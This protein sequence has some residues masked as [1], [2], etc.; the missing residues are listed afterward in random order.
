MSAESQPVF[1]PRGAESWRD[2]FGMYKALRDHDP[3]HHVPD[4]GEGE[5]YWVLSRFGHVIDAAVDAGTFSS[6]QGL[7][8]R[9][10]EME[11]VGVEAPIVMMDPPEHTSLRKL[12]VKKFTPQ[13]VVELEPL[14]REFVVER[15][16]RL[17]EQGEGDV[18]ET[19]LK[20][21]PSLV[22]AHFL[23]VPREDREL[24]D[25]WSYAI[26]AANA[27]GDVLSA[28][29]AVGEMMGY[30]A[31]LIEK[32][33][34]DPGE[35]IIS[36]LVHGRLN[37]GEEVSPAKILGMGFTMVTGGND[38]TTG[39]LGGA[40][41]LLTEHPEQR[42]R[43]RDDPAL[44]KNAVDE[45]LR[46]TSPVQG[47]ARTTTR[48]VEIEGKIIPEGRKVMLLYGSANRDEREFGSDAAEFDVTRKIR[49]IMSFGYGPHHCIGAA[50]AR[51]QARV[52]LEELLSRCPEFTVDAAA[53]RYAPGHFV[54][55]YESLPFT[56]KG[57]A[58]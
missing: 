37:T 18:V 31:G 26:V 46:L 2:P 23:G 29:Q 28:A 15:V 33:K 53:G 8:F 48:D 25:R 57:S 40:L 54:R 27:E 58:A 7:T 19:L 3:V 30:F 9:Y 10:G 5:D 45:F 38:T 17:R 21:L 20:P 1:E 24:F 49:R 11:K 43:L 39:L 47:L 51:L 56:A 50:I 42:A 35:D 41:E 52:A 13:Q 34:T 32:R 55:R 6:A 14:L 12:S 16:E 36:A 44:L 22:V 4:N